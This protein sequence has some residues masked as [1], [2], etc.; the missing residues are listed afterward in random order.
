MPMMRTMTK[1]MFGPPAG[2][3]QKIIES[4]KDSF[5]FDITGCPYQK[6]CTEFGEPELTKVFCDADHYTYDDLPHFAF[7]RSQTLGYGGEKCD[8]KYWLK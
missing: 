7:S 4:K 1:K 5:S 8:F 3:K 6:W 2:F